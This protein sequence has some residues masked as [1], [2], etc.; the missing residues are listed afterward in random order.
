MVSILKAEQA[1]QVSAVFNMFVYEPASH[2]AQDPGAYW[3]VPGMHTAK[4]KAQVYFFHIFTSTHAIWNGRKTGCKQEFH[5]AI[6][7]EGSPLCFLAL[8]DQILHCQSFWHD[9]KFCVI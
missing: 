2:S 8:C 7:K 4:K 1:L 3:N 5:I 9:Q 6:W